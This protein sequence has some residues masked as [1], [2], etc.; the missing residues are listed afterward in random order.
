MS[1]PRHRLRLRPGHPDDEGAV[2]RIATRLADFPVPSWRTPEEIARADDDILRAQLM[3][4]REDA[5]LLVAELIPGTPAGCIL[6]TTRVDYFTHQPHAYIEVIVVDV[7]AEGQ[8][9]ASALMSAAEEWARARGLGRMS[10]NVW[11]SNAK[12]RRFYDRSGYQTETL[13]Y[14]KEL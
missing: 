3:A 4:P 11:E 7:N 10:L 6:V 8:G 2:L 13:Q 12:A 5:L 1:T 9:V 14:R